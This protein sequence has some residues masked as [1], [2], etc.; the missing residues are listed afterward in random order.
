MLVGD[1]STGGAIIGGALRQAGFSGIIRYACEG[2]GDVNITPAE[3]RDIYNNGLELGI[4]LEHEANWLL[5]TDSIA[6][7]VNGSRAI[8][9]E[10]NVPDGVLYLA[11]DFDATNGGPTAPGSTGDQNMHTIAQS[12]KIAASII[13]EENVGWYGSTF[14]IDWLLANLPWVR[15]F[16]QTEAWSRGIVHP[17]AHLFQRANSVSVN[18][19]DIDLDPVLEAGVREGWGARGAAIPTPPPP[20]PEVNVFVLTFSKLADGRPELF[21]TDS[22]TGE[23]YHTWREKD[24]NWSGA[25]QGQRNAQ[26]YSLGKPSK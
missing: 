17:K 18:N 15:W 20:P 6:A 21:L 26:W 16:W 22:E 8:T 14:G 4:V 1:H 9:R 24:G 10:C 19:V 11:A 13:G 12:F 2:R 23:V 3:V 7:R 5:R 25:Q